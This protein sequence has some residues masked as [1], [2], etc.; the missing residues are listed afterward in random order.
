MKNPS[1]SIV[2]P[3]KN[4][5]KTLKE[6]LESLK[7]QTY[8]DYE[9]IIVDAFSQDR[10]RNIAE[11]FSCK[12]LTSPESMSGARNLG[13][14]E[15][16][17]KI[18]LSIDSDMILEETLLEEVA[19]KIDGH[20]ALI[21]PE[22]GYGT[23]FLSRCKDLEKRCYVGDEIIEAARAFSH[24]AFHAVEGYDANLIFGEDWDIH[25]RIKGR[26]STSRTKARILHNTQHLSLISDLKKA[27]L[28]GKTLPRY[29]AKNHPQSK[30]WLDP[31]KTFFIRHFAKLSKE[32]VSALGLFF[33][34]G[35]KYTVGFMGL[36]AAKLGV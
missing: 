28:Y 14:S 11:R 20:G 5:E 27:Y 2:I 31:W 19:A 34:K 18:F 8:Q 15:A 1:I 6:C 9:L 22:V 25:W 16:K 4:S 12:Y 24:K 32:P 23:D 35:M 33:L 26:F 7:N 17:G 10:T 36:L 29:L 3:T 21:I 13:F 30:E